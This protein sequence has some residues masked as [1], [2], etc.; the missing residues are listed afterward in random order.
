[1]MENN[2][3]TQKLSEELM[4]LR[5]K[6]INSER[7]KLKE[8]YSKYE[9]YFYKK[10]QEKEREAQKKYIGKCFKL[11]SLE[12]HDI[13]AFKVLN[14]D[15]EF[16]LGVSA[17]CIV[18]IKAEHKIEISIKEIRI[19]DYKNL[20]IM[21]RETDSKFINMYDEFSQEEF[22]NLYND[23]VKEIGRKVYAI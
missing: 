14:I 4:R 18:L 19:F 2:N 23:Y 12:S 15:D 11:K 16:N 21:H 3:M 9:M 5:M 22:I 20:S 8:E 13:K 1:M 6:E 17:K 7:N 10:K